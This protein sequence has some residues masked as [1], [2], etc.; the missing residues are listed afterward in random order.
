VGGKGVPRTRKEE[1]KGK[2]EIGGK[3]MKAWKDMREKEKLGRGGGG[4]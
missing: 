1:G 2:I 3:E 4:E